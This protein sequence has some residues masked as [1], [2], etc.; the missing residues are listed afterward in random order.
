MS[1]LRTFWKYGEVTKPGNRLIQIAG[2]VDYELE[3]EG[4][5]SN[6]LA[7]DIIMTPAFFVLFVPQS[8]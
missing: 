8:M 5:S 7:D 4:S 1:T 2:C 6:E 3:L